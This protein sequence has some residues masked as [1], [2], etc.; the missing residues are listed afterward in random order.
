MNCLLSFESP[1]LEKIHSGKVRDS[2]R[3]DDDTRMIVVT[4]RLSAFDNVL[5][6]PIPHKG[7]VLNGISN[8]WFEQTK[9]IVDSHYLKQVDPNVTLVKEAE[10]IRVEMIVRGYITGSLWRGYAKGQRNFCG[11]ELPDGLTK[12]QA[13]AEPI[14]TPTTKEDNDRPISPE[15]IA[16]EGWTTAELYQQMAEVSM[17]LFKRGTAVLAEKGII[18]V[19]TKYEF[20]LLNGELILID[21]IHT[22][23]SSRFW[24]ADDYAKDA[25]GAKENSKEFVRQWMIENKVDG[26][27]PTTLTD[28]IRDGASKIYCDMHERITGTAINLND[29]TPAKQRITSNLNAAG[30]IADGYILIVM[31]SASDKAH[32]EAI[33]EKMDGYDIPVILRVISAHKNGE[34]LVQLAQVVNNSVEPGVVIAVAGRSNGLGGALAA[35]L[36][37]PVINCPP[38]KHEGDM[39][40]NINSSLVMPSKTPASTVV[41]KGNAALSALRSLN[42]PR[43]REKMTANIAK[44]KADLFK[45]D[46]EMMNTPERKKRIGF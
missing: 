37:V 7:A 16:K 20:G 1:Q 5:E 44:M 39:M 9:D 38:F 43:I 19:D 17:K 18:L 45:A 29:N 15:D 28:E 35:N 26:A 42:I 10:P 36:S 3:I 40:V 21:E 30:L 32:C 14:L 34:R 11:V 22:P 2:I 46:Q 13:F 27:Y 31:G 24:E 23:D 25:E 6:T 12:N 8:W 4:D 41:D 33:K